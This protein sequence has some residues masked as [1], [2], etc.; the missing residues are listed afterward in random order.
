MAV[1]LHGA[2]SMGARRSTPDGTLNHGLRMAILAR[3]QK[4]SH[5]GH[6]GSREVPPFLIQDETGFCCAPFSQK[7]SLRTRKARARPAK[8]GIPVLT[9]GYGRT[10]LPV[11]PWS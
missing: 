10:M 4:M 5:V 8:L 1:R 2:S 11:G 3:Y 9:H 6:T 7:G